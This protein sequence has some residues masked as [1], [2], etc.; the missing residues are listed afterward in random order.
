MTV[1]VDNMRAPY[2][3]LILCHMI[4]DTDAELHDMAARIGVARRHHQ[5][6]S[7]SHYD[8]SLIKR[9]HAVQ[10]GA[11]EITVRQCA[12]MTRPRR[13][14]PGAALD[15]SVLVLEPVTA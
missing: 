15:R 8:I 9:V 12:L 4:A 7:V 10:L 3:R 2:G 13:V 1:Y 11:R 5:N 6:R 14:H